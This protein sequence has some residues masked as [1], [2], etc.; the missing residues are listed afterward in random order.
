M[1]M[2]N[3]RNGPQLTATGTDCDYTTT[4]TDWGAKRSGHKL[5][6]SDS[7]TYLITEKHLEYKLYT[8][9]GRKCHSPDTYV[10]KI[11][12]KHNKWTLNPIDKTTSSQGAGQSL[13]AP[14]TNLTKSFTNN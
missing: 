5:K 6:P 3:Y 7:K 13:N 8:I 14:Q 1:S 11:S 4:E 2:S 9:N 10:A 12:T